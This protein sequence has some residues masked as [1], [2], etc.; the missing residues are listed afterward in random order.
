M[1]KKKNKLEKDK[2]AWSG[3]TDMVI[4]C[5]YCK[6]QIPLKEYNSHVES[7]QTRGDK[8]YPLHEMGSKEAIAAAF[9]MKIACPY[10]SEHID[11]GAYSTHV[12]AHLSKGDTI[13]PA[14]KEKR[15]K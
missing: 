9:G 10:C 8:M 4:S 1:V 15:K 3:K 13:L 12:D 11:P 2:A 5:P 6:E 14:K 7:H